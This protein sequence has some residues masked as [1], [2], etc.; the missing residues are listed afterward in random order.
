MADD[1]APD[2]QD[3]RTGD[4]R[5]ARIGAALALT[6]VVA[7]ITLAE[8]VA[9]GYHVDPVVLVALLG[10][11]GALLGIEAIDTVRRLRQ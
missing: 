1:G 4:Y 3:E 9:N 2:D 10:T 5:A 7:I 6:A 11:I 8:V